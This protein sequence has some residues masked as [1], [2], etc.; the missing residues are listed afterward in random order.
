MRSVAVTAEKPTAP[1]LWTEEGPLPGKGG[2]LY[3]FAHFRKVNVEE[4]VEKS[5]GDS[6]PLAW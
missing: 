6:I 1:A 2:L 3:R 5:K 4:G